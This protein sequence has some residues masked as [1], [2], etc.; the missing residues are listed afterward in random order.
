MMISVITTPGAGITVFAELFEVNSKTVKCGEDN[1][2]NRRRDRNPNCKTSLQG[3]LLTRPEPRG[4]ELPMPDDTFAYLNEQSKRRIHRA[5]LGCQNY[6]AQSAWAGANAPA[7]G[8]AGAARAAGIPGEKGQSR[9]AS[10]AAAA[11]AINRDIINPMGEPRSTAGLFVWCRAVEH[12]RQDHRH[13]QHHDGNAQNGAKHLVGIHLSN[14]LC[15]RAPGERTNY[16]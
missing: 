7:G 11:V 4:E 9:F 3:N 15:S 2:R 13:N 8:Q 14:L 5:F 10:V 6:R 12:G 1:K 16:V